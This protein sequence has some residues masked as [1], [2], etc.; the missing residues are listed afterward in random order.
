MYVYISSWQFR[1][2]AQSFKANFKMTSRFSIPLCLLAAFFIS[3]EFLIVSANESLS[4]D[5]QS[6]DQPRQAREVGQY[7]VKETEQNQQLSEFQ[8]EEFKQIYQLS[9]LAEIQRKRRQNEEEQTLENDGN[10]SDKPKGGRGKGRGPPH[11]HGPGGPPCGPPPS[12][13]E[14]VNSGGENSEI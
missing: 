8:R 9:N 12:D 7:F 1:L 3:V 2:F 5:R 11:R 4:F 13:Q 14:N 10:A 6:G